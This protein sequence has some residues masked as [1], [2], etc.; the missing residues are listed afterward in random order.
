MKL[1]SVEVRNF[2]RFTGTAKI[3]DLKPG[4]NV[5]VGRNEFGK[6]TLMRAINAVVFEKAT[7][8]RKEVTALRHWTNRTIPEVTM[9]FEIDGMDWTIAK[10]FAGAAGK[11]VLT[12]AKGRRFEGEAAEAELKRMFGYDPDV[13]K[14]ETD[15]WG[16]L[17]VEQGKSVDPP[18][19]SER[20][21]SS[22]GEC[23]ESHVGKV[24]GGERGKAIR[25]S[26]QTALSAIVTED[27]AAPKAAYRA[28]IVAKD[29]IVTEIDVLKS[30]RSV[31]T[32]DIDALA[33]ASSE[34]AALVKER[35]EQDYDKKITEADAARTRA[36][37]QVG[38]RRELSVKHDL[39]H[40]NLTAAE[41]RRAQ[42]AALAEEIAAETRRLGEVSPRAKTAHD[43]ATDATNALAAETRTLTSLRTKLTEGRAA[44]DKLELA[45]GTVALGVKLTALTETLTRLNQFAD[46]VKNKKAQADAIALTVEDLEEI[47]EAE[48][49]LVT[50]R[51]GKAAAATEVSFDL[52]AHGA[53]AV[54]LDG[55]ALPEGISS[56]QASV[57]SL[58]EVEKVGTISI[59]PRIKNIAKLEMAIEFAEAELREK[60]AGCGV[61]SVTEARASLTRKRDLERELQGPQAALKATLKAIGDARL[62]S[63][64]DVESEVAALKAKLELELGKLDNGAPADEE[65]LRTALAQARDEVARS[66]EA[67]DTQEATVTRLRS[68]EAAAERAAAQAGADMRAVEEL[69]ANKQDFLTGLVTGQSDEDLEKEIARLAQVRTKAREALDAASAEE[70]DL[71]AH[72]ATLSRLRSAKDGL[73]R[74]ISALDTRIAALEA[75]IAA[76]ASL[77]VDEQI[78]DKQADSERLQAQVRAFAEEAEVLTLLLQTIKGAESEAKAK[79]L[80]PVVSRVQPY[81]GML[82]PGSRIVMDEDLRISGLLRGDTEEE[83]DHLSMGTQEQIAVLTRL[84]LADLMCEQKRPATVIL[85]DALVY[86]DDDRIERMFDI[87]NRAAKRTQILVFTCRNRLF[88]RLGA[89]TVSFVEEA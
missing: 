55:V 33:A 5:L 63:V 78:A 81:L 27:R 15:I 37:E 3:A 70:I 52:T 56:V 62:K 22:I 17:W 21:R 30:K 7:S 8:S 46:D 6:S 87:L 76:T 54:K 58:I 50:A 20:A 31:L 36:L 60:L 38:A 18:A 51:A 40:A 68:E 88:S 57:S 1:V 16:M 41:T 45:R 65:A 2:K 35:G 47:E 24:V 10:R 59:N 84:A 71:D 82:I 89:N 66:H 61:T 80:E 44:Q 48:R 19:M 79:Y 4:L 23:I 43:A 9:S 86:S 12:D 25:Q 49:G 64:A 69:I 74:G 53:A 32:N 39:A 83:M 28:A 29:A 72:D 75:S 85:D 26:I 77:G 73:T 11:A 13:K 42:R 67:V 34:R 14:G